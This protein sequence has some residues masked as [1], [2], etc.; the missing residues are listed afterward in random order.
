MIKKLFFAASL[1]KALFPAVQN[2]YVR[3]YIKVLVASVTVPTD[4]M[5]ELDPDFFD[6][7]FEKRKRGPVGVSQNWANDWVVHDAFHFYLT[8]QFRRSRLHLKKE[9]WKIWKNY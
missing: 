1:V 7:L 9:K 4:W 5:D 3:N 8:N 2:I 6:D